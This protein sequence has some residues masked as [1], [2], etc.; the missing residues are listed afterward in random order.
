MTKTL[1]QEQATAQAQ[2]THVGLEI[3]AKDAGAAYLTAQRVNQNEFGGAMK[4]IIADE[5]GENTY[6]V[7]LAQCESIARL[8]HETY[9]S[10]NGWR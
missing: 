3:V 6:W 2:I 1:N 7:T 9:L 8:S 4:A 5:I 10:D